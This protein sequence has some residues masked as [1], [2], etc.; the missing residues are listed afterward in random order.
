MA[1]NQVQSR[2]LVAAPSGFFDRG[3]S[4]RCRLSSSIPRKRRDSNPHDRH[5]G[6]PINGLHER[7][8]IIDPMLLAPHRKNRGQR[9]VARSQIPEDQWELVAQ[10]HAT[11]ERC[12]L[13]PISQALWGFT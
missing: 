2:L 8:E 11:R 3:R 5:I 12:E 13:A 10:R 4:I 7:Q 1:L 9:A 6:S